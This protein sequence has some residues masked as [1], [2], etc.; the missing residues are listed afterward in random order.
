[1]VQKVR[2]IFASDFDSTE[3]NEKASIMKIGEVAAIKM[4]LFQKGL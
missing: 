3:E 1:M 2:N 4:I